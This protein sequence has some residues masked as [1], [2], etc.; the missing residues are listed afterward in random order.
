MFMQQIEIPVD[1]YDSPQEFV[2]LMPLGGVIKESVQVWIEGKE[3]VIQW[4]RAAPVLKPSLVMQQGNCY[5]GSF[6]RRVALPVSAAYDR[7]HSQLSPENILTVIVPKMLMPE[8][9]VV[10]VQ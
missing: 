1:L 9:I 2:V 7:I 3:L 4:E 8:K 5:R 6:S 10:E